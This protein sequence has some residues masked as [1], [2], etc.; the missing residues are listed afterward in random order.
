MIDEILKEVTMLEETENTTSEQDLLW[1]HRVE[2]QR[3]QKSALTDI[4]E[5]KD[6]DAVRQ[7]IQKKGNTVLKI[8]KKETN[9]KIVAQGIPSV[10]PTYGK[11][12]SRGRKQSHFKAVCKPVWWQQ[13]DKHGRKMIH[14]ISHEDNLNVGESSKLDR[15]FA[16]SRVKYIN[17]GSKKSMIFSKL[18]STTGQRQ[19]HVVYRAGTG[20]NGN[21]MPLNIFK[22]LFPSQQLKNYIPQK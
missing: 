17:L 16:M 9:A 22:T 14:D 21:L 4:K 8:C 5:A 19:I 1:L 10:V 12:C 13:Q 3:A 18:E 7:N 6:F 15:S 20:A 2:V 11:K